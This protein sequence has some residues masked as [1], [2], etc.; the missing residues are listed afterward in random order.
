MIT[1]TLNNTQVI[2]PYEKY[3]LPHQNNGH[4]V[5][6]QSFL[7]HRLFVA[8]SETAASFPGYM[9]GAV[10]SAYFVYEAITDNR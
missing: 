6:Q 1:F 4:P 7:E 5:F 10:R 8:G 2:T 3:V 9:D